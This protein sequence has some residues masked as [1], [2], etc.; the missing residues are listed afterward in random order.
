MT[1]NVPREA[2]HLLHSA[3]S[4][5]NCVLLLGP[6]HVGKST[7]AKE[8]AKEYWPYCDLKQDYKDLNN[9]AD[10][11][12]LN[13]IQAFIKKR[14]R[15]IIVLDEAQCMHDIFPKLRTILDSS[16]YLGRESV[17]WLISGSSTS[18]LEALVNRN[19]YGRHEKIY[20]TPFQLPELND[21]FK[22]STTTSIGAYPV[23]PEVE[24]QSNKRPQI[25][26]LTRDP[27]AQRRF[28]E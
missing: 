7:L 6:K 24:L 19:L 27:L 15:K 5:C 20:L 10:C 12:Q 18:Q 3:F 21:A 9:Q 14:D 8:F 11:L 17:R 16:T 22:R 26:E 28:S 13:D 25:H 2:R 4:R 23:I 1:G